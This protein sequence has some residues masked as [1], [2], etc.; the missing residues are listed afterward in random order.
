MSFFVQWP[1]YAKNSSIDNS[2]E[3][4]DQ[5]HDEKEDFQGS[6]PS[7]EID[8]QVEHTSTDELH[9]SDALAQ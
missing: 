5:G 1:G 8:G 9:R 4:S 2:K 3:A 6:Q 7:P